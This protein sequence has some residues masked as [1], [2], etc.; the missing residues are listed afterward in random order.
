MNEEQKEATA[1]K[2]FEK[3]SALKTEEDF[4]V[5]NPKEFLPANVCCDFVGNRKFLNL[6]KECL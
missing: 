4:W 6:I 3:L 5:H 1:Q 2:I